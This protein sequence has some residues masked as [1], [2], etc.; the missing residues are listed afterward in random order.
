MRR[1]MSQPP[2]EADHLVGGL[3]DIK[4]KH[5]NWATQDHLIKQLLNI[6]NMGL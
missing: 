4:V 5:M 1:R 6:K 2:K 3:E